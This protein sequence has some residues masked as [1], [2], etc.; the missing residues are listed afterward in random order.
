M[1]GLSQ[2][3]PARRA[4]SALLLVLALVSSCATP[5]EHP[6]LDQAGAALERA[7]SAPQVRARAAAELDRAEAALEQAR[8]A[9]RAGASPNQVEHLGYVASQRAAFAETR[10]AERVARSEIGKRQRALGQALVHGRPEQAEKTRAPVGG[11][12]TVRALA[13]A[14]VE[15]DRQPRAASAQSAQRV[16]PPPERDQGEPAPLENQEGGAAPEQAQRE[17]ISARQ[18]EQLLAPRQNDQREHASV[19]QDQRGPAPLHHQQ[20]HAAARQGQRTRAALEEDREHPSLRRDQK[21]RAPLEGEFQKRASMQRGQMR[22]APL[23]EK[24]SER[25][26]VHQNREVPAP[27]HD[28]QQDYEAVPQG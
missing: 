24:P 23:D 6:A 20:E 4:V 28:D 3:A 8:A 25:A 26:S 19:Q 16:P 27:P 22:R 21:I 14:R 9:A 2:R 5:T 1:R 18:D 12:P 10:A 7:R 15:E 11:A 13:Q 17:R